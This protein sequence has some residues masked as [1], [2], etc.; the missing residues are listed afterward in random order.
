M[1]NEEVLRRAGE[2]RVLIRT[3]WKRKMRWIGHIMRGDGMLR[4]TIEGRVEGKR[5]RGR[6]RRMM[7]DDIL[8][9]LKYHEKKGIAQE[10]ERWRRLSCTVPVLGQPT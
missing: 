2:E 3:I 1:R 5:P 10:R 4:V 9:E 7:L 6:K 8:D